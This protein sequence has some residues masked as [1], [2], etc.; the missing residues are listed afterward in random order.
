MV[1]DKAKLKNQ[2]KKVIFLDRDGVINQGKRTLV[3][4][5]S[6]FKF[7]PGAKE[8][9]KTFTDAGYLVIIVTNQDVVGWGIISETSLEKIHNNMKREIEEAGGKIT[10]IYYCPHNPVRKC[11]CRKPEP[12]MLKEAAEKYGISPGDSWMIGDK[13]SD[14]QAGRKFGCRTVLIKHNMKS[15]TT[16]SNLI[17]NETEPDFTAKSLL[18]AKM[19]ILNESTVN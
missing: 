2:N 9:I 11:S 18:E 10:D 14:V 4:S 7:L 19:I 15:G 17:K 13:T 1:K 12:G 8:A 5:W 16:K 6:E 3:K